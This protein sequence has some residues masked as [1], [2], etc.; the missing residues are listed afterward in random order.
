MDFLKR[1]I[2]SVLF[3]T[4]ALWLI[5]WAMIENGSANPWNPAW[6]L[7]KGFRDMFLM[8]TA[9]GFGLCAVVFVAANLP[10]IGFSNQAEPRPPERSPEEIKREREAEKMRREQEALITEEKK[11]IE[12]EKQKRDYEEHQKQE[13][14]RKKS[15]SADAANREALREF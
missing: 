9:V 14:L 2:A 12:L 15:C 3:M 4:L 7:V 13:E 1:G 8:T 6:T 10:S 11:R 5:S